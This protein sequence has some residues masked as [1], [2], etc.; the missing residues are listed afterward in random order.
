MTPF[1]E[2]SEQEIS[3]MDR[4]AIER[5]CM[6]ECAQEGV[7]LLP[8]PE[9]PERPVIEPDMEA[10]VVKDYVFK[11]EALAAKFSK[12]F[13]E[14]AGEIFEDA[15]DYSVGYDHKYLK[16]L[17]DDERAWERATAI[18]AKKFFTE[19]NFQKNKVALADYKTK[20]EVY[21]KA[22]TEFN[23]NQDE[24]HKVCEWIL[25]KWNHACEEVY[26]RSRRAQVYDQY[27]EL[28]EK[29]VPLADKFFLKAYPEISEDELS[30][31]KSAWQSEVKNDYLGC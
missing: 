21:D 25:D 8:R 10:Y 15:Y 6:Y 2:L 4:E 26:A 28:A 12:F 31:I 30:N 13:A 18:S 22:L 11:D 20:K 9:C 23:K 19:E 14:H 24:R 1:H 16:N 7:K 29:N 17:Y 27:W 3:K 5:Y